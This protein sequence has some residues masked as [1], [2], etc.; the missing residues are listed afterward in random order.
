[1]SDCIAGSSSEA[2]IPPMIAQ[3]TMTASKLWASVMAAAPMAYPS[4]PSTYA[5]LRPDEVTHLAAD[6]DECG[7]DQCFQSDRR[8]D[9]AHG[10]LEVA[11][12]RRD[13]H[14]HDRG[15][16]NEHEHRHR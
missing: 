3:K 11:N 2:P 7:R 14:V 6:Q 8:L 16:D 9:A 10:R 13:G 5:R 4:R 1:M 12:D 15:V